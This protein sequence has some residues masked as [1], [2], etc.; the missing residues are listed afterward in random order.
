[1][2]G[3]AYLG[4]AVLIAVV[5]IRPHGLG[6]ALGAAAAVGVAALGGGLAW[7]DVGEAA[8]TLWRPFLTLASIMTVTATAE[9]IGLVEHLASLIEPRTRGPVKHAFRV[10]YILSAL[11]ATTLSNDAAILLMTP[12]VLTLIRTVYPRRNPKFL[13]PFAFC[14]FTAAG[15][16]PLVISN[17]MNLVVAGRTGI[18]F[19]RYALA[20]VPVALVGWGV[21]YAV[22]ARCFRTVLTDEAPALGAWPAR[23]PLSAGARVVLLV[24]ATALLAYPVVSYLDGPLWVVA[25]AGALA[26]LAVAAHAR[27]PLGSVARGVSWGVFPFLFGV[28]LLAF[29]LERAGLVDHLRDVYAREPRLAVIGVTSAVG[30]ALLDNHP[31][32]LLNLLAL[33]GAPR[34][35]ILAALVGGD[36]G[37]RLSPMGSLAGLLWFDILRR[38]EVRV[39]VPT[40]VGVG[41]L[42]TVPSL[43]VSLVT[44]WLVA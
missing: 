38:H 19:N 28:L 2:T 27:I 4:L 18:G 16:A 42:V 20:M 32:A 12:V 23:A 37:P 33:D 43:L 15:V 29:A 31:M 24:L 22:L 21:A 44:L 6:P 3:I 39:S 36:L 25:T 7:H 11:V 10:T 9:R 13:V 1:V 5:A 14:V 34:V 35:D 8:S 30:S 17:P 40:F 41:L 26:C